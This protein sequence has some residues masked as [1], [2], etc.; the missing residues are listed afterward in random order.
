MRRLLLAAAAAFWL[1]TLACAFVAGRY[2]GHALAEAKIELC[3][4]RFE[5]MRLSR[6]RLA[7]I[8]RSQHC[9]LESAE[10]ILMTLIP[11]WRGW[12]PNG[13][14]TTIDCPERR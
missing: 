13:Q 2:N 14:K 5:E 7:R 4:E 6:E 3:V 10:P 1:F 8:A 9:S 12:W 11:D